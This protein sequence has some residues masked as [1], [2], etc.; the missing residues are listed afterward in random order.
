MYFEAKGNRIP[1]ILD[2]GYV[3]ELPKVIPSVLA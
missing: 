2:I 1:G 3:R